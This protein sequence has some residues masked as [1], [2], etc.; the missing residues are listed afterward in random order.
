MIDG[1]L[2]RNSLTHLYIVLIVVVNSHRENFIIIKAIAT[3]FLHFI[4]NVGDALLDI[5]VWFHQVRGKQGV[6]HS[7]LI[8]ILGY[9]PCEMFCSFH[10]A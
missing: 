10:I 6:C 7:T 5:L 3:A 9:C 1:N 4:K 8:E 2:A